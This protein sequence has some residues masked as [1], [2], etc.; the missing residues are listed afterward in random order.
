MRR[1]VLDT[2]VLVSA[3]LNP[4]GAPARLVGLVLGGSVRL[5]HDPRVMSEYREVLLRP[6]LGLDPAVVATLLDAIEAT[7]EPVCAA[8]LD[9]RRAGLLPDHDDHPFA[10]VALTARADALCT[11]NLRNF[12]EE[13]LDPVLVLGPREALDWLGG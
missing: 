4:A 13:A 7:G 12:A 3:V 6:R 5:L 10:E 8:P 1:I 11:R 9:H 2:N